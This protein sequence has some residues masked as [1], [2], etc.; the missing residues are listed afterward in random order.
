MFKFLFVVLLLLVSSCDNDRENFTFNESGDSWVFV[1]NEGSYGNTNGT[2]S[3][4]SSNGEYFETPVI[5]DVVQSLEVYGNKLIVLVNNSHKMKIFDITDEGL[6]MPGVEIDL[7]NSSPREMVIIDNKVYFTNWNSQDIKVFNLFNYSIETQIPVEGLPEDIAFDGQYLWVTIPHSDNF[8][9]SGTTV[10]KI[11]PLLNEVIQ[12]LDV[13]D[14]PQQIAIKGDE[15]FISRTFYDSS[16]NSFYGA[17]KISENEVSI[18]NYGSGAPC[19]GAIIS[20]NSNMMR[21]SG[22]GLA[23]MDDQLNLLPVSIGDFNQN[24]VYHVEKIQG[25][26]WFALTD[27][28]DFN[29]VHVVNSF[30][31]TINIFQVG[32]LPGDFAFWSN[33]D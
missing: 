12:T 21:S 14:G 3:M 25:N 4:I 30:G 6:S 33:N 7:D 29:E 19:G 15:I 2:I 23:I 17:S 18:N 31:E 26:F 13:G 16:W 24:Q 9:T 32:Y 10:C 22:G 1:A 5:G 8:F 20:H 27:Y 11:D 28:E